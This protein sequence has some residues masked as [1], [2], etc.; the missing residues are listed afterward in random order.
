M[1][2]DQFVA[3]IL[4]INCDQIEHIQQITKSDNSIVI[5][6][7]LRYIKSAKINQ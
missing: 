5:K 7:K 2:L 6:V 4:N 1:S 3:D